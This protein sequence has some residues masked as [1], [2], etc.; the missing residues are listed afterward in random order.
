[1][2]LF[3]CFSVQESSKTWPPCIRI[4]VE[5]TSI[6]S[7]KTGSLFVITCEGG[8]LGREGKHDI[9]LTDIN[10]SKH[11]LKFAF[12]EDTCK[13]FIIDLGSR[14]GTLLNGTRI[15]SSK[16][17]SEPSEIV[18]GARIQIGATILL[19]HI[20]KG[21]QT[22][23]LCEP[24]LLQHKATSDKWSMRKSDK[25]TDHK[26]QLKKLK[27]KFA[28]DHVS[29]NN[30]APGYTDRAQVRRET[31]GSQN[32]HEKTQVASLDQY[33]FSIFLCYNCTYTIIF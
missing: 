23:G 11:H 13:Y 20:H 10:V 17:E 6:P 2:K 12:N 1:M 21:T 32:E 25:S 16:Q 19:C 31:V 27:K 29:D 8:T 15:S 22:C 26:Q 5:E 14:N 3:L 28:V 24:G 18:H 33:G 9:L 30:L 7:V 4:I